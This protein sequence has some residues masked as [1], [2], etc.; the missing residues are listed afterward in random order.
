MKYRLT[1][2]ANQDVREITRHIRTVQKSPQ[3]AR[4]VAER[5]KTQFARLA[6]SPHLGHVRPELRDDKARVIA[7]TGVLVIYDPHL[8]PLTILRVIHAARDLS[9]IPPRP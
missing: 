7:V 2:A 9:R 5:L 6:E 1:E 4:L 8:N 3:N